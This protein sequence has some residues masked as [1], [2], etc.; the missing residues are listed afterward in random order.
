[1]APFVLDDFFAA[2][3]IMALVITVLLA[4]LTQRLVET[5]F[6][7]LMERVPQLSAPRFLVTGSLVLALIV[8]GFQLTSHQ[9]MQGAKDVDAGI[10]RVKSEVSIDCFGLRP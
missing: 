7:R 9:M 3:K 6:R 2:E 5:R 10:E 8:G 4:V 1:M